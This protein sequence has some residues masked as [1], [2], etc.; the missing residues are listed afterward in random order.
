MSEPEE[1]KER[2]P[3]PGEADD[4]SEQPKKKRIDLSAPQV[5]AGGVA[6]LTA[7]TAASFL[8]VYGTIAGAAVMSVISTAGT[9]ITQRVIEDGRDKAKET[10]RAVAD[11][12]GRTV[13][14]NTGAGAPS[15]GAGDATWIT[16]PES[17]ATRAMPTVNAAEPAT[18]AFATGGLGDGD[19]DTD[20]ASGGDG[21]DERTWWQRYRV[22]AISA[23]VIFVGVMVVILV[24]ELLTGRSLSDTVHGEDGHSSPSLLGGVSESEDPGGDT[25]TVDTR[26]PDGERN[27]G[28]REGQDGPGTDQEQPDGSNEEA[29]QEPEGGDQDGTQD[30]D[31]GSDGQPEEGGEDPAPQEGPGAVQPDDGGVRQ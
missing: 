17:D 10:A 23:A 28:D 9:A 7:A 5:V 20:D 19:T 30:Q 3:Y 26:D 11:R 24:F 22:Y 8:G 25:E 12:S 4:E 2:R 15:P 18:A 14:R 6:T 13:V 16:P 1:G 21:E 29:P 27:P 31:G